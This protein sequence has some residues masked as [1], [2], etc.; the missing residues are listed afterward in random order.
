MMWSSS[1]KVSSE[2]TFS[3]VCAGKVAFPFPLFRVVT[4]LILIVVL[5]EDDE[6]EGRGPVFWDELDSSV[7]TFLILKEAIAWSA[8]LSSFLQFDVSSSPSIPYPG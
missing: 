7:R 1:V 5:A 6:A 4:G 8:K 3:T 2:G